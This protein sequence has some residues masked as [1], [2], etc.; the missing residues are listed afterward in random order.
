MEERNWSNMFTDFSFSFFHIY[1]QSLSVKTTEIH[2]Y[3]WYKKQFDAESSSLHF[4]K[5]NLKVKRK[6]HDTERPRVSGNFLLSE[7]DVN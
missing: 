7:D 2:G 3:S 6:K 4:Y 1:L 5:I